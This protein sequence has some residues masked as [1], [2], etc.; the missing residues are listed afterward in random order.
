MTTIRTR[1]VLLGIAVAA[2]VLAGIVSYYASGSPDGL[3]KVSEDKGFASTETEHRAGDGPFAGYSTKDIGDARLAG[4]L[5]GVV[6]VVVV[7][8]LA[9]GLVLLV[10]RRDREPTS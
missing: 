5:A 3:T 10:R 9:S 8:V 4:G 6:G 1:W 2:V 7:L